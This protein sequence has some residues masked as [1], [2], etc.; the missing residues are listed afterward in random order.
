MNYANDYNN[1]VGSPRCPC[2][3][4]GS[5]PS[6]RQSCTNPVPGCRSDP[7]HGVRVFFRTTPEIWPRHSAWTLCDASR[8][9]QPVV[10][11][12]L[13]WGNRKAWALRL[14]PRLYRSGTSLTRRPSSAAMSAKQYKYSIQ[15]YIVILLPTPR[16]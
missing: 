14:V 11:K 10:R 9:L 12:P 2:S 5:P 8:D 15:Y 16:W 7:V 6:P 13:P 3:A 1:Y 4:V